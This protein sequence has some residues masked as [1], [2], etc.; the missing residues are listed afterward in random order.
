MNIDEVGKILG[1]EVGDFLEIKVEAKEEG[2]ELSVGSHANA[3]TIG[4]FL[5]EAFNDL[6]NNKKYPLGVRKAILKSIKAAANSMHVK[7]AD[8]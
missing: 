8:E 4:F 5:S 1:V 7:E 2:Y 3:P 6:V